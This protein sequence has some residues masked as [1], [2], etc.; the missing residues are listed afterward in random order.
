MS[1]SLGELGRLRTARGAPALLIVLDDGL[2]LDAGGVASSVGVAFGLLGALIVGGAEKRR[3]RQ[4]EQ[5]IAEHVGEGPGA[6]ASALK[7]GQAYPLTEIS[8]VRLERKGRG[9]SRTITILSAGGTP[10][11]LMYADRKDRRLLEVT[12]LLSAAAGPKFSST[13][14][15]TT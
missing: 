11:V 3:A 10:Q 4:R 1:K 8:E 5:A 12:Q 2:V 15:A 7:R 13:V 9:G 6:V 14:D